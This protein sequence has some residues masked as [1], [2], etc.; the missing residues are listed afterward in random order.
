MFLLQRAAQEEEDALQGS[1]QKKSDRPNAYI[2]DEE[3]VLPLPRPYGALAPFK[4]SV[5][6]SNMRHIRKPI[7]KPIEI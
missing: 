5:L 6:G 2:P 1:L 3:N 7:I 4:P